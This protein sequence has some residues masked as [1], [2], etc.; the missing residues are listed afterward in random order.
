V[1]LLVVLAAAYL[2][3]PVGAWA[4]RESAWG[5]LFVSVAWAGGACALGLVLT[6]GSG[7]GAL[8][9]VEP[10]LGGLLWAAV[11]LVAGALV[12]FPKG[13]PRFLAALGGWLLSVLTLAMGVAL[14]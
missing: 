4:A 13:L 6:E 7:E 14:R 2:T 12:P 9:A 3:M 10:I 8:R 1:E 5:R 11:G